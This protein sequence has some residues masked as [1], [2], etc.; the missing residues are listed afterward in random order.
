[1]TSWIIA[2]SL[3]LV[4]LFREPGEENLISRSFPTR[5]PS[6]MTELS[7]VHTSQSFSTDYLPS[8]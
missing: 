6:W 2:A 7:E 1:M 3:E 5:Y 4:A 8:L